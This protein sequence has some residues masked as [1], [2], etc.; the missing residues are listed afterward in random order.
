MG[1]VTLSMSRLTKTGLK[2][3]IVERHSNSSFPLSGSTDVDFVSFEGKPQGTVGE[4]LEYN[5][6]L[7]LNSPLETV[8]QKKFQCL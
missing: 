6:L 4:S 8:T 3:R 7:H 1:V 5:E 2:L